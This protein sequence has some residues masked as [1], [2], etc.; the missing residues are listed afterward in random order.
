MRYFVVFLVLF[1]G[2][3]LAALGTIQTSSGLTMGMSSKKIMET[4]ELVLLGTIESAEARPG[5]TE[6]TITVLEYVKT[7]LDFNKAST[8]HAVGCSE[9]Q[10]GG[11]VSFEKGQDALFIL[12][13]KNNILRVS[14]VSF[15]SPN[16]NCTIDEIFRYNDGKYDGLSLYQGSEDNPYLYTNRPITAQYYHFN[17]NLEANSV[18]VTITVVDDFPDILKEETIRLD[19]E[20]CQPNA[21]AEME[22]VIDSPGSFAIRATVDGNGGGQ[23]FGGVDVIDYVAPPLQ[24]IQSGISPNEVECKAYLV[25]IHKHD[26]SPACVKPET[27]QKLIERGWTDEVSTTPFGHVPSVNQKTTEPI[28]TKNPSNPDE[29]ILDL[30]AMMQVQKILDKC[31]YRQKL[32]SGEISWWNPDGSFNA[33]TGSLRFFNNGTHYIDS[34]TCEWIDSFE[35][36]TYNCFEANPMEQNWYTGP[37][38]FDNGTHRIDVQTCDW[39]KNED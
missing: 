4:Q 16:P 19:L 39:L 26:G 12:N 9:D 34:N 29:L 5:E 33:I 6:Y 35:A 13:E 7:P 36:I 31:D 28:Y 8:L 22:F 2:I 25:L 11:C 15:V 20:E 10:T 24:Q 37:N 1:I 3:F 32:E 30:D 27:K 23:S 18:D 14:E 17:K 38:Y 21:K